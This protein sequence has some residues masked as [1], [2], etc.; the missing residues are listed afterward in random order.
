MRAPGQKFVFIPGGELLNPLFKSWREMNNKGIVLSTL[1]KQLG[2]PERDIDIWRR[3]D[4]GVN[5]KP[6]PGFE[7]WG[8]EKRPF[9]TQHR[10]FHT[11]LMGTQL[12]RLTANFVGNYKRQLAEQTAITDEWSHFPDLYDFLR[13]HMFRASVRSLCGDLIFEVNPNFIEEYWAYDDALPFLLR[14]LP[15]WISPRSWAA[16]DKA[17][18]AIRNWHASAN[19]RFDWGDEEAVHAEWEPLFGARLMRARQEM[20]RDM[21]Q[22]ADG[23]A[24]VDLGMLWA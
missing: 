6:G 12:D 19:A 2:M 1:R 5:A 24:S 21:G 15:R 3:D 23:N 11:L 22:S 20:A 13:R 4:S 8:A 16:R 7:D 17:L 9:F 10:D 18:A 14:G